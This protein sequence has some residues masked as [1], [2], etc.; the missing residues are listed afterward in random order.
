MP[1][2]CPLPDWIDKKECDKIKRKRKIYNEGTKTRGTA[3]LRYDVQWRRGEFLQLP[4][5]RAV[6]SNQ[7]YHTFC[8]CPPKIKKQGVALAHQITDKAPGIPPGA[9]R[10]DCLKV[11]LTDIITT[12]SGDDIG[13]FKTNDRN[14]RFFIDLFHLFS[15]L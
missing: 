9:L 15:S 13:S 7:L 10:F 11:P 1:I 14:F 8:K 6:I 12:G 2:N 5:V 4:Q 3:T